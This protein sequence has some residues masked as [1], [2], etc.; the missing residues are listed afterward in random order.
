MMG[1]IDEADDERA[2][3]R[4]RA[5]R[6]RRDR[7]GAPLGLSRSTARSSTI[8]TRLL[9][10]LTATPK[11]EVDRNTYR[12]FD[13][14]DRRADRRLRPRRSGAATAFW[15]R[16][17]RC[18]VPLK[19]PREGIRYDDL[20]DEEKGAV[21]RAGVGR[22]RRRARD[23]VEAAGG[24]QVAVQRRHRRQ[25]ARAPDDARPQG[26]GRRPAR[27]D[28]HLRQE[29]AITPSSSP[30]ASTPTTRSYAGHFARVDRLPDASTRSR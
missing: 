15:C 21:G 13:L 9:V 18:R 29:P 6:P 19:F 7:R 30:S 14:R 4:R 8:S 23:A 20:S 26:R 11:D 2:P 25:G 1:L 10:G 12:L 16:R 24:Q 5:F 22:G 3:L 28:D 17:R 27:Q